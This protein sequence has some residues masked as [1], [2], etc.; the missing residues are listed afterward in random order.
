MNITFLF[1]IFYQNFVPKFLIKEF[2]LVL[3]FNGLCVKRRCCQ[4][5]KIEDSVL[6]S[7]G[8]DGLFFLFDLGVGGRALQELLKVLRIKGNHPVNLF[9]SKVQT[10]IITH[11]FDLK[12]IITLHLHQ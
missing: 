8:W 9:I 10:S 4:V 3:N 6:V 5:D 12:K 11:Q 7:N 1:V 2:S